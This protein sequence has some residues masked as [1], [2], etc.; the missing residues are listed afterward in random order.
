MALIPSILRNGLWGAPDRSAVVVFWRVIFVLTLEL[1]L[2]RNQ[3]RVRKDTAKGWKKKKKAFATETKGIILPIVLEHGVEKK[4]EAFT[5]QWET[6]NPK[7]GLDIANC[8]VP[9]KALKREPT[10]PKSRKKRS[11]CKLC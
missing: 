8:F 7:Q 4:K 1:E 2:E 10:I 3:P 11:V 5:R 9:L 6:I